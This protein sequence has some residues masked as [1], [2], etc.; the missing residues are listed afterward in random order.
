MTTANG[1]AGESG[2]S[3]Q[4]L[5]DLLHLASQLEH[6]LLDAYLYT[7]CSIKS[8]P[9][10]FETVGGESK[11]ANR[12]R[13]IQFERA[14][15]WKQ[16]ILFVTHEEMLHLHYVQCLIRALGESPY[17][18]LPAR[19]ADGNWSI[20]SW[21][22]RIGGDPVNAGQGVDVPVAPLTQQNIRQFVLYEASDALQDRDP[23]GEEAMDM[24][25]RL[26]EFELDLQ[27]ESTLLNVDDEKK[28]K[29]L[30]DHL[31]DLYKNLTPLPEKKKALMKMAVTPGLPPVEELTFQSIAD[32][33]YQG[34]LPLYQQAYDFGWV[35]ETNRKLNNEVGFPGT[36]AAEGFLPIGP[37][38]RDK[39]FEKEH[40]SNIR[41]PLRHYMRVEDIVREIVEEGE[42]MTGFEEEAERLLRKVERPGGAREYLQALQADANPDNPDPT[43][44]WL[45][46]GQFLRE[47]HLYR[48]AMIMVEL[49]EEVDLARRAGV[50][51]EASRTPET[52]M[53][54]DVG[55]QKLTREL[56][57]QFNAC[58][59][60]LLAWLA[61]IYEIQA[62]E[63]DKPRRL[64]IEML[65]SWPLMSMA[66]RPFLE[67][68]SHLPVDLRQMFKI[69]QDSLPMLPLHAQQLYQLYAGQQ[70]SEEINSRMDY[71]AVRALADVAA[72]ASSMKDAVAEST[73]LAK[74]ALD[75]ILTRLD[76]LST[77]DEFKKQFPFRVAGGY[78][79]QLPDRTYS[80]DHPDGMK[81]SEDPSNIDPLSRQ[82]PKIYDDS[83]V[84][85][86]RF[87]G[88]GLV[89]L[90]TDP[91]PTFDEAGCTGTQMLHA[92]DMGHHFD[93]A[94]VW[95]SKPGN[96]IRRDPQSK[97]PPL[98]VN[99]M[100]ASLM[101]SDG[102]ASVGY[103]PLSIMSSTGAVQT[104]GVQQELAIQNLAEVISLSA[105][106]VV[107]GG[108]KIRMDLLEKDGQVPFLNG[109]NHVIWQDGE[110]IDPFVL[111]VWTDPPEG[112]MD[113]QRPT[114]FLEREI[115]NQ[116]CSMLDME[117]LERIYS[118]RGPSGFD[119]VG[120][121]PEWAQQ[122]FT[123][124][125]RDALSSKGYPMSYLDRR[126]RILVD[127]MAAVHSR[128]EPSREYVD[129]I[130]SLAE[131][132]RLVS[133]PRGT[134]VGWLT[135]LLHYGHSVSGVITAGS[136]ENPVLAAFEH[137]TGLR[138]G[139]ST[140]DRDKSNTRWLMKYTLGVMDV[141]ALSS[142]VYAELYIP[143]EIDSA[144][145]TIHK[146]SRWV[147]P[148]SVK[149][150]LASYACSFS[151]PFWAE[152]TVNGK[153]R[154]T[155]LTDGT[156]ITEKLTKKSKS[157]YR[158]TMTGI[159]HL[160]GYEGA[161]EIEA[162]GP[163]AVTLTWSVQFEAE[164][165]ATVFKV[166][167]LIV[168]A[169]AHM[170]AALRAHFSP[171]PSGG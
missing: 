168:D 90:A 161:F 113:S 100:Q 97:L 29:A 127:E 33:Y 39:N 38:N 15:S 76:A 5:V 105:E 40:V 34:V 59:L 63:A 171:V 71:F 17:F 132:S 74:S 88:W 147:F 83:L 143:L 96:V 4:L 120:S 1:P 156:E 142:F 82:A 107:D 128:K 47:S 68:A 51:F 50:S 67:L 103:V 104:S 41:D 145:G 93:R 22:A 69:E 12:R 157:G 35:T 3:Y 122:A 116:G 148:A 139:V 64:A 144:R 109:L 141:D 129:K 170:D 152:F 137:H 123:P 2:E 73:A 56:P 111:S 55:L 14:R 52:G 130:I 20:P 164:D 134:T 85:R 138:L 13:A 31:K 91:D 101:C 112:V 146:Q 61:R 84:L 26:H 121:I 92:A 119:S 118:S 98:G 9:E 160:V 151:Q 24:F 75:Q 66:I 60:V 102:P 117:P 167:K 43:P 44:D 27:I 110:P 77:L 65:A 53:E 30:A 46:A 108:R 86:M 80:Q 95:Q 57:A 45:Q 36:A 79:N 37:I 140:G 163:D 125:L 94:L 158:Y 28:K 114:P 115:F 99:C 154:T 42:G 166:I 11:T 18:D 49:D 106:E 136:A 89:Q 8:L 21:K 62:W 133:V 165:D 19:D 135:A 126:A 155:K 159:D 16:S 10:E 169:S 78:S 54:K 6:S 153:V 48:F 162:D 32:F 124:E 72:W 87:A 23:F 25:R 70:R 58:Y 150:A 131:R 7:A 81:Y 149:G